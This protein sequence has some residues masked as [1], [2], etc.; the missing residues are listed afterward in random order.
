MLL[1]AVFFLAFLALIGFAYL[2]SE[3]WTGPPSPRLR[4]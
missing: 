4:P 1:S 2:V 3:A